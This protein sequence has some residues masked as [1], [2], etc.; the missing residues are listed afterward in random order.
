MGKTAYCWLQRGIWVK[1][2]IVDYRGIWV[3]QLIVDCT[4]V[5]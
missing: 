3:K 4:E 2:I 5:Y 1:Q